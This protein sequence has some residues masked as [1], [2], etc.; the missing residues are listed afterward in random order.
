MT[1][2]LEVAYLGAPGPTAAAAAAAAASEEEEEEEEEEERQGAAEPPGGEERAG[3]PTAGG[4]DGDD[5]DHRVQGEQEHAGEEAR[6]RLPEESLRMTSWV[7][8]E[9]ERRSAEEV[10]A[11]RGI[12]PPP[13][14]P[15]HTEGLRMVPRSCDKTTTQTLRHS[16]EPLLVLRRVLVE[17]TNHSPSLLRRLDAWLTFLVAARQALA[18]DAR[19]V[20]KD[21]TGPVNPLALHRRGTM[22]WEMHTNHVDPL[23]G[24]KT[25]HFAKGEEFSAL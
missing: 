20:R 9:K 4:G 21:V 6:A 24:V 2:A 22:I 16:H 7:E 19:G 10:L 14:P 13:P 8:V 1:I 5:D 17:R 23:F 12:A 3:A 15:R 18:V 11:A 25:A